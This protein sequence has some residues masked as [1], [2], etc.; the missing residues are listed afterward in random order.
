MNNLITNCSK[1]LNKAVQVAKVS[2]KTPKALVILGIGCVVGGAVYGCI[3]STKLEG[4]VDEK[5]KK[6]NRAKECLDEGCYNNADNLLDEYT[7]DMYKHD[8]REAYLGFGKDVIKLY[9]GPVI[10]GTIGIASLLGSYNILTD[11][12]TQLTVTSRLLSDAFT[13]YRQN[14]IDDQGEEADQNY[15]YGRT[16]AK[17]VAIDTVDPETGEVVTTKAKSLDVIKDV[18]LNASVYA[19]EAD[20]CGCWTKDSNYNMMHLGGLRDL[21]QSEYDNYGYIHLADVYQALKVW[22]ML[23]DEQRIMAHECGWFKG[24]GCDTIEFRLVPR[25][26]GSEN[27]YRTVSPYIDFNCVGPINDLIYN[28]YKKAR[29]KSA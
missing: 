19:V 1:N 23:T 28:K 29:E 13:R 12:I 17:N 4:I 26:V 22:D 5:A 14:V 10:I 8:M 7:E 9:S 11:R 3:Q 24:Q 25:F 6:I 15:L 2:P 21:A 18:G 27:R 20:F 16:K